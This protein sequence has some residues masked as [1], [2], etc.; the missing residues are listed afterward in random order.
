MLQAWLHP[1]CRFSGRI[2]S[3][4][5][6]ASIFGTALCAAQSR[7]TTSSGPDVLVLNNGDTLH[8]KLVSAIGGKVTFE[9]EGA[10]DITLSWSK[11][12]EL[13]TGE[14][15]A[16]LSN[17]SGLRTRKQQGAIPAGTLVMENQQITVHPSGGSALA[18][19]PVAGAQYVIA[20]N[21][22]EK[23]ATGRPSLLAGWSGAATAGATVV[24]ATQNQY[25][26]S[27]GLGLAR[28]VPPVTWLARRNRTAIDF[29]GSFGK[30]TQPAYLN[31]T[32]GTIVPAVITKTAIY[33]A[34]AERDENL[35]PRFFALV[36]ATFDHNFS[37]NLDLQ[38]IY[39][40]GIGWTMLKTPIQEAN[41]KATMQYEKQQFISGGPGANQNLIGSTF[42]ADYSA[43]L[44]MI[45]F[46]QTLAYI[47]AYN[48]PHAY[49]AAET[50]MLAIPAYKNLSFSVGTVDS[51]LN[52]PPA[53]VN[54]P[55]TKRNSFQFTMGLTF[56]IKPKY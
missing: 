37:Q 36:A 10:G 8:G 27:G 42:S 55:P 20:A 26:F 13:R 33:H 29:V 14:N 48:N 45:D 9:T 41:L 2:A 43:H 12:K 40:A 31:T 34:D 47:P 35:T 46:S 49:S 50:D 16:V 56:A 4:V 19:M 3:F 25:T 54:A 5:L 51:Y 52:G 39:G 28:V 53:T 15:F 23:E 38:Q 11:I 24:T 30:I 22:L 32:T 21:Q 17:N 1:A 44:K 7:T 18:P 6:C